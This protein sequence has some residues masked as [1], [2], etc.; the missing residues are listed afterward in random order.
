[1]SSQ[2]VRP[3]D[4][5]VVRQSILQSLDIHPGEFV[6]ELGGGHQPF[7]RSDLIFDKFPVDNI[8]RSQDL[9]HAAP[10][11][12]ADATNMPLPDQGCDVI[13]ASHILE[14]IPQ[15]DKFLREIQRCS[16]RVYLEFP[17]MT[18]ELMFAWAMH[19]WVI[20]IKGTHLTFYREDIPQLFGDFFHENYDFLFDAWTIQRHGALNSWLWCNA[21]D[22]TWEIAPEGAFEAALRKARTGKSKVDVAPAKKVEY[23]WRQIGTLALQ[24]LLPESAM[25][26]LIGG[27]RG[28]RRGEARPLT[29]ALVDKL[30]CM[31]CRAKELVLQPPAIS[32]RACGARYGQ[33]HG[34]YDLDV[35]PDTES[36][37][38]LKA[39]AESR[40]G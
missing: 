1:M 34:L 37:I 17:A 12:I 22:L 15:P 19:E 40:R 8:H 13:F 16:G 33:R 32:C 35:L 23:S 2:P 27:V 20:T 21:A 25:N 10:V 11:I 28:Q 31:H 9:V 3:H 24:K 7:W 6:V 29:Q 38:A 30:V 4:G 18:R 39:N 5:A 26:A 14:H 36:D